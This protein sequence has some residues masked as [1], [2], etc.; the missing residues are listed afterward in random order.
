MTGRY[1]FDIPG[2]PDAS[3]VNMGTITAANGGFAALVAPGV[4]NSGTITA[5]LGT[6]TLAAGN[7]FS[8]DFYG[9]KL[10]T[11]GV[12][13]QIAGQVKD[14][15]TGQTL[16]SLVTNDGKLK[17][18]G[19]R[20][21][22]TA[23]A[24]RQ[25]VDSVINTSGV[26]EA[27]SVRL[28]NGQI[29]LGQ[30]SISAA[31]GASKGAGLPKQT[32][33]IAGTIS[34]AG[35]KAGT[36]GGKIVVTGENIEVAGAKIDASGRAGGGTV[37]IGGDWA[38][39]K[40]DK[41]L[42]NNQSAVLDG[43]VIPTATTV[44]IDAASVI[45]ASAK[46]RG[47]GGKVIVW[48]DDKTTFAGTILAL[49]GK[50]FGNGGFAEVSGHKQLD[51]RGLVDLRALKGKSGVLLL[52][53]EDYTIWD[54]VGPAP[55]GSSITNSALQAQLALSDVIIAT[56]NS[57]VAG[58]GD[59]F[60]NA[61][62]SWSASTKLT[63][64]AYRHIN[65]GVGGSIANTGGGSLTM[66]ADN[67]GNGVGYVALGPGQV[68]WSG[69]TGKVAIYY[70]PL[71]GYTFPGYPYNYTAL[72]NTNISVP[73]QLTAYML[74]NN[75]TDLQNI[76]NN[77]AGTY[78]L[79]KDIDPGVPTSFNPL[80]N[81]TG[82]LDG[83]GG[84]GPNRTI[85]N[86]TIAPT[87]PS[88]WNIGLFST[89]AI[90]SEI[91]NLNLLNINVVANSNVPSGVQYIG[92]VAGQAAGNITN[93]HVLSGSV[94]G[95]PYNWVVAGGL[96]GM[97][98]GTINNSSSAA[99][100]SVATGPNANMAG[101]LVG[102][103]DVGGD[104]LNS[105][106]SGIVAGGNGSYV[107]GLVGEVNFN[108]SASTV[109]NSSATG[110]VF[111]GSGG[112]AGGLVGVLQA[113]S[114]ISGNSNATGNVTATGANAWIGGLV[115]WNMGSIANTSAGGD[116]TA[117]AFN[118]IMAGGLVGKNDALASITSS[119]ASGAVVVGNST[120]SSQE[121]NVGGLV[122]V[123]QGSITGSS[124]TGD[125]TGGAHSNVGGLV[126]RNETGATIAGSSATSDVSVGATSE[127][128]VVGG[129]VG[130]NFG[131]VT[132]STASGTVSGGGVANTFSTILGGFVGIN[133]GSITSS[134]VSTGV[135]V[136]GTNTEAGGF[137]GTN[138]G[139]ISNSQAI[140][141]AV[142]SADN[143]AG[144]FVAFNDTAGTI[145]NSSATAV[146]VGVGG[147]GTAGGF[148][149]TNWGSISGSTVD[150]NVVG[151]DTLSL[152]GG[153]V[154]V[155]S[156][157]I[158]GS[159]A[160]T[161]TVSLGQAGGFA[162]NNN[163]AGTI[164]NSSAAGSVAVG[165]NGTAGGF[166]S[167]NQG[168]I[169]NS[170]TSATVA[171]ADN[172]Y[173]GGFAAGNFGL[174]SFST[175]SGAV[176][177]TG[178]NSSIGGFSGVN[179]GTIQNSSSSGPVTGTS[180][181]YLGG[182]VG[183]NAGLVQDSTSSSPVTGTG[184]NNIAGGLVGMNFGYVDPSF[185][186]GNVTSGAN[187]IVGGFIGANGALIFPDGS[188]I[189]GTVSPDSS[190]SGTAT[191]GPGSI[192]GSQVGQ[193]YPTAGT[194]GLP[195]NSC[196][197][198]GATF[199]GGTLYNPNP[200]GPQDS[201]TD[202]RNVA[203]ISPLLNLA[204]AL[205]N[206]FFTDKKQPEELIKTSTD[207][208]PSGS[209][210]GPGGASKGGNQGGGQNAGKPPVIPPPGL[211]PLP[212]GMPPVNETRFASNEV[213]MQ[214]G[215]NLTPEQVAALARQYGLEVISSQSF[216][217]LGRTVY[218]FRITGGLSVRDAIARLETARISVQPSYQFELAESR[219][220]ADTN[221]QGDSAQY[222][223]SKLN[224][225]EAHGIATGKN[226]KIAVID[227][228]IDGQHPDLQGVIAAT[229]DALP[230]S[231]QTPH[232]H[233]TGMAG[234]IGSHQRL[235]GVAPGA[236]ILGIRAFGVSDSGAQGTSMNI[237]KGLEWAIEQ[238]AQVINM[239]FAGPRDPILEQAIKGLKDKG[240]ILIAAAG[241]A[242]PKSP[243]LF[244]GADTNVIGVSA[245]DADNKTYKNANRGPQVAIA[246]PG[247]DI[248]VPAPQGGYQLTTGTSV[249][250]AHISGVVALM[251]ERNPRLTPTDIR[252][253]LSATAKKLPNGRNDVGAGLVD[254]VQAL[255]K[256][257]PKSAA[258][259]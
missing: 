154:G 115:G 30:V 146:T 75:L 174:I 86:L 83:F 82:I 108:S 249:A 54:G 53:P 26:I 128:S 252:S 179:F 2:R 118:G 93:V 55:S 59:I 43:K 195:A 122:G 197:N 259:R 193:Q 213:V 12:N 114:S 38:G 149:G 44:S 211:G 216:S 117:G 218:R 119:S 39:G 131:N 254:P 206:D 137:A 32:V 94:N 24:A 245:T 10:I 67:E 113:G 201:H 73:N 175:A 116:V 125:V 248:L 61:A 132:S 87:S 157:M 148:A 256:S 230:S 13:D 172:T 173:L 228:G 27:N 79:G 164:D 144:G 105:S 165:S 112:R 84:I 70:T 171:G 81:F 192:T 49:G 186:T 185:S 243:P 235:L 101:G 58:N 196:A 233:G 71:G 204:N 36:K 40:P 97:A 225:A 231:D 241:N 199:C 212:S 7:T 92:P 3:I 88:A 162:G 47:D 46:D 152:V 236:R 189:I 45:D 89:T 169:T 124:G 251:L 253:I 56:N 107:G 255:V 106:A 238:G 234:A 188:T 22:L 90:G 65:F 51:F 220:P 85:A 214:L 138:Q 4:R 158:T 98:S 247:V 166:V 187:S 134:S 226:V 224:L 163:S 202:N 239:S 250:A 8:L 176:I 200:N 100:T 103:L 63:L 120:T 18:N 129:L 52:D 17:A 207:G 232:P 72:V 167:G 77:L 57:M 42:V 135:V 74:V 29:Q 208:T 142:F 16:K 62:V 5:N 126:G 11:L 181:S 76:N 183:I 177:G 156:G 147:E 168:T 34:A 229:F 50:E 15:A 127:R 1:Q 153:F 96:V 227:S 133:N 66:R 41:S 159:Q 151:I 191:G 21:E 23:A 78:A 184:D 69:S 180:A 123:N 121:N 9:D 102:R 237:V 257:G 160:N 161:V 130:F 242:G 95:L 203:S 221:R 150:G 20:V 145:T 110:N 244:P 33:K 210:G 31:T 143:M 35:R 111:V 64:S 139:S 6:V 28:K 170:T 240:I 182:L 99:N 91:R 68:D 104:V 48:S 60:V 80:G 258:A 222:I 217:L 136:G 37:M 194:P 178:P 205:V 219:A 209:S 215:V 155:N 141:V 198:Q 190:G 140:G 14:V 19:G 109:V 25:V 223:V 246:A